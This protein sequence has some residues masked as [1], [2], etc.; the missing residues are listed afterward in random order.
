MLR[1]VAKLRYQNSGG[2]ERERL[3]AI[4]VRPECTGGDPGL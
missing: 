4:Y 1:L 2:E 3:Y